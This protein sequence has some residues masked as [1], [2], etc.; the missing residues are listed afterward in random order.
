MISVDVKG[1]KN[2]QESG[3]CKGMIITESDRQVELITHGII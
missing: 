3:T 2:E 1:K